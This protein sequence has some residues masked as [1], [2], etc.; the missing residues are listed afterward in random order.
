MILKNFL[1]TPA[2]TEKTFLINLLL[3]KIRDS[4]SISLSVA[5]SGIAA[6]LLERG[7]GPRS[8]QTS[9]QTH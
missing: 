9:S 7:E 2:E 3:T 4:R 8:I 1:N 5:S 6:T